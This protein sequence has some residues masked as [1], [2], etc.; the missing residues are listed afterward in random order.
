MCSI[1]ACKHVCSHVASTK[2][3]PS[4]GCL[5][6]HSQATVVSPGFTIPALSRN[7][8]ILLWHGHEERIGEQKN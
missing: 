8:T 2:S 3:L 6:R 1:V 5:Q 4:N 7:V